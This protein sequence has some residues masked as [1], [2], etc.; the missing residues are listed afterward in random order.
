MKKILLFISLIVFN[1][2]AQTVVYSNNFSVATGLSTID[3]DGDTA[4]WGLFT[5]DATTASWGLTGNFA[6][7]R[8]WNPSGIAP[9]GALTPDNFL[10]TP[11]FTI[12][13]NSG[14]S[15]AISFKLGAVDVDFYQ[16]KISVYVYPSAVTTAAGIIATTPVFTRVLTAANANTA[17]SY[18]VDISSFAGQSVRVAMRHYGC[19]DQN[20]LYFDDL[21]VTQNL[22]STN[23]FFS[24]NFTI[25][26]NPATDIVNISKNSAIEITAINISD[27]NGRIVKQVATNVEAISVSDLSP[28]IYFVKINTAS[29]TAT[30]KLVKN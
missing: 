6:G 17:L 8:S 11:A 3:A 26:P 23:E 1:L 10:I 14:T 21:A 9:A 22:L 16:E 27:I 7:S 12:P 29:G 28:G 18:T 2:Q 30:T 4:N 5:G 20:L 25:Y 13:T 15:T 19:T 24:N